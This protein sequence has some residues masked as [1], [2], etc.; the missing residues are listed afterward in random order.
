MAD[1]ENPVLQTDLTYICECYCRER[2]LRPATIENYTRVVQRFIENTGVR[3]I[4]EIT[5]PVLLKWR[6]AV[7]N[8]SS[9]TT[10]NNYHRHMKAVLN[11]C[12]EE[13]LIDENPFLSVKPYR[14]VS[15]RRAPPSNDDMVALFEYLESDTDDPLSP[16]YLT[17]VET[18]YFTGMRSSQLCGL[19][20]SDIDFETDTILLRKQYSKTGKEWRI[21]LH[22]D[23]S[24]TLLDFMI[25]AKTRFREGFHESDQVFWIQRYCSSYS[26]GR[27]TPDKV[28]GIFKRLNRRIGIL[29]SAHRIRHLFATIAANSHRKEGDDSTDC[30]MSLVSLQEI[31]GHENI[32][33]TTGY[34]KPQISMQRVVMKSIRRPKRKGWGEE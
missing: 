5:K 29:V 11:Y 10:Y 25:D 7:G 28:T 17:M 3:R 33:T 6:T 9:T 18:L 22:E 24:E 4:D 31:L 30:P 16:F 1:S 19:V 34:I 20:W 2:D 23:L 12:V 14:R 13:R 8:R 26:G 32:T 27:L 15:G 21:A